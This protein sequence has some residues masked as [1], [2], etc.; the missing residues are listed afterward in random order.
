MQQT[1]SFF[2]TSP[3]FELLRFQ[4]IIPQGFVIPR[5][6][7]RIVLEGRAWSVRGV[8]HVYGPERVAIAVNLE[9]MP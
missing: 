7:E 2:D 8:D 3:D 9:P 6:G 4:A 1:L 5:K